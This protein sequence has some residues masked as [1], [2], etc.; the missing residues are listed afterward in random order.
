[1][2]PE[3]TWFFQDDSLVA[4]SAALRLLSNSVDTFCQ[5][6]VSISLGVAVLGLSFCIFFDVLGL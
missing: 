4:I 5:F 3:Y 6:T 1:V 2:A